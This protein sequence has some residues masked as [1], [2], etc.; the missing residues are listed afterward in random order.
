MSDVIKLLPTDS[1]SADFVH[2]YYCTLEGRNF[3]RVV[4]RRYL[5]RIDEGADV[6]FSE[7]K[8]ASIIA[9]ENFIDQFN[10]TRSTLAALRRWAQGQKELWHKDAEKMVRVM[11]KLE[12]HLMSVLEFRELFD[13]RASS[14]R[15]LDLINA[16][17][18]FFHGAALTRDADL[19]AALS[20]LEGTFLHFYGFDRLSDME[21]Y[22]MASRGVYSRM[23]RHE[24]FPVLLVQEFKLSNEDNPG[25]SI[26][27]RRKSGFALLAGDD[28]VRFM[29]SH[30]DPALR[31]VE[32]HTPTDLGQI[33]A[34][35]DVP[36]PPASRD[37][38]FMSRIS[39]INARKWSLR[40][41]KE[42]DGTEFALRGSLEE[43]MRFVDRHFSGI[44]WDIPV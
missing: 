28:L 31:W 22:D 11:H 5:K 24:K 9:D 18:L 34:M 23:V 10:E 41:V 37:K 42:I 3:L 36:G 14:I 27:Q 8:L 1:H 32:I 38:S 40:N 20:S 44:M 33:E 15:K 39:G 19:S 2:G 21:A 29:I 12:I 17:A 35:D 30:S 7:L 13:D 26:F 43:K 25:K 6:P 16:L 4:Y